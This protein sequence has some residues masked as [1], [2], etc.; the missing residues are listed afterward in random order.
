MI[1]RIF[2][3][4]FSL[5]SLV[6]CQEKDQ[7]KDIHPAVD[8][9][10]LAKQFTDSELFQEWAPTMKAY[11]IELLKG[12][13]SGARVLSSNEIDALPED[14]EGIKEIYEFAGYK[15]AEKIA[16]LNVKLKE[17]RVLVIPKIEAMKQSVGEDK[18]SEI[19]QIID[20]EAGHLFEVSAEEA[21][22]LA[23]LD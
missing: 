21:L 13:R 18:F 10:A 23:I 22:E 7:K 20:E 9:E 15:N 1:Y 4:L 19:E 8:T 14:L 2:I 6:A 16:E 5:F 12:M 3:L 11:K 17:I